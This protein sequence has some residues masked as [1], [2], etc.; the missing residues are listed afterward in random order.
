MK[1]VRNRTARFRCVFGSTNG[2]LNV[3]RILRIWLCAYLSHLNYI[4]TSCTLPSPRLSF[5]RFGLVRLG[6]KYSRQDLFR[7]WFYSSHC[8]YRRCMSTYQHTAFTVLD[9][10][11]ILYAGHK[12]DAGV[13]SGRLRRFLDWYGFRFS[14]TLWIVFVIELHDSVVFSVVQTVLSTFDVYC[15]YL[16]H[17]NYIKPSCILPSPKLR[18]ASFGWGEVRLG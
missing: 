17:L 7:F 14:T 16:S 13:V 11:N 2:P 6:W 8:I 9:R 3:R 15:A 5:A 10:Y 12:S 1:S 4:K 18:F